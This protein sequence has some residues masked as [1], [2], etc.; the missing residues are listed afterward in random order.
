M[1]PGA[2]NASSYFSQA[3][4][5]GQ[6]ALS[7][8]GASFMSLGSHPLG[9][10]AGY[11]VAFWAL[12]AN[13]TGAG[14]RFLAFG[15]DP[16]T[17]GAV[18]LVLAPRGPATAVGSTFEAVVGGTD[19]PNQFAV[20]PNVWTHYMVSVDATNNQYTLYVNG[21]S[22]FPQMTGPIPASQP[23]VMYLGRGLVATDPYFVGSFSG[24]AIASYVLG[25]GDAQ[26]L[27][28]TA[29]CSLPPLSPPPSAPS[30]PA[31]PS[32]P[33]QFPCLKLDAF[34]TFDPGNLA[35]STLADT[36][37]TWPAA[38]FVRPT[39]N[40]SSY[41]SQGGPFGQWAL[42]LEGASFMSLG[43]HPLVT[44]YGYSV[45]FWALWAN[46]TG[47][48]ERFLA[49]GTDMST[50][51]VNLILGPRGP[52]TA[53]GSTFEAVVGGT[54][55]PNQF[56]VQPNVW[57]HYMVSVANNQYTLYV[58]G[59]SVFS[60]A[61]GTV[62]T[63]QP[64]YMYLGR[65]LVATDPYFVGSFSGLAIASFA[66]GAG[67]A[68]I[69]F[70][71]TGCRLPPPSPPS[72]PAPPPPVPFACSD[73]SAFYDF[74]P[75]SLGQGSTTLSSTP[76][77]DTRG[78]WPGTVYG[79]ATV[80]STGT[81]YGLPALQFDG[82][83]SYVDLGSRTFGQPVSVAF[84]ALWAHSVG[85]AW[86]R[87]FDFS[88][89]Y[90]PGSTPA[91][92][93]LI[94]PFGTG[95]A[96]SPQ[97]DAAIFLG[98]GGGTGNMV[99]E[100][101][102]Q[103][104]VWT[105]FVA[106]VD[107]NGLFTLYV[108]GTA[109]YSKSTAGLANTVRT[110]MYIGK[111]PYPQDPLFAGSISSF[112][113]A[114]FTLSSDDVKNLFN[115]PGCDS[116]VAGHRRRLS[117]APATTQKVARRRLTQSPASGT[118][119][120]VTLTDA[121]T[122][123]P[124]PANIS[125]GGNV[126]YSLPAGAYQLAATLRDATG[127]PV[128]VGNASNALLPFTVVAPPPP[129]PLMLPAA[130]QGAGGSV[131]VTGAFA[132]DYGWYND[133]Q[134]ATT[135]FGVGK[136][137]NASLLTGTVGVS[138]LALSLDVN[139][140][141]W[142]PTLLAGMAANLT[143]SLGG[144]ACTAV[145]VGSTPP[146]LLRVSAANL[147]DT[148]AAGVMR[149]ALQLSAALQAWL[150]A[151]GAVVALD[152]APPAL[153]AQVTASAPTNS[154]GAALGVA[155]TLLA[156]LASAS[157]APGAS[158]AG[159]T[160]L[161]L[162]AA[163]GTSTCAAS[164]DAFV[165]AISQLLV[166]SATASVAA[167]VAAGG[168]GNGTAT[169]A[170]F[171]QLSSL[172][173]GLS[174]LST[175][176]TALSAVQTSVLA[177]VNAQVLA[178]P[179]AAADNAA[180]V[181]AA[182]SALVSGPSSS[183]G[184]ISIAASAVGPTLQT[185]AT[186]AP[187]T[188]A[189]TAAV[190]A[191]LVNLTSALVSSGVALS[192]TDVTNVLT[193]LSAAS[194]VNEAPPAVANS[195]TAAVNTTLA[196]VL[197]TPIASATAG[198]LSAL[199]ASPT[200]AASSGG[201]QQLF[202]AV[203]AVITSLTGAL[204]ARVVSACDSG[205]TAAVASASINMAVSCFSG[206]Q[207]TTAALTVPGGAASV[208]AVSPALLAAIGGGSRRRTL[209][210]AGSGS[211]GASLVALSFDPHATSSAAANVSN[212]GGG[213][214][215]LQFTDT[216]TGAVLPVSG[217]AQPITMQ[218]ALSSNA[219]SSNGSMAVAA[220]YWDGQ[221]GAYSGAG[222]VAGPNPVAPNST[223]TWRTG[224]AADSTQSNLA[225]AW[226][227]AVDGCTEQFLNC[228][229]T[230]VASWAVSL[231]PDAEVGGAI[232][233]CGP[234]DTGLLRL[235]TGH[236]CPLW[237]RGGNGSSSS[238]GGCLWNVSTQRFAGPGCMALPSVRMATTHTTDFALVSM[239]TVEVASPAQVD[240]VTPSSLAKLRLLIAT[241][242]CLFGGMH[243][244]GAVLNARDQRDVRRVTTKA[245]SPALGCTLHDG[246]LYTWSLTQAPP[247][248]EVLDTVRGPAVQ[249]AG[250]LGVPYGR[251][252]LAI[253]EHLFGGQPPKRSLGR[254]HGLSAAGMRAH[255]AVLLSALSR[256]FKPDA[257]S[258]AGL[259]RAERLVA[260]AVHAAPDDEELGKDSEAWVT[261]SVTLGDDSCSPPQPA[262]APT[263]LQLSSTAL[264]QAFLVSWCLRG[265]EWTVG[266]QRLYI[267][268]LHASGVD[269]HGTRYLRLYHC[270]K[271][272]LMGHLY[273]SHG[274]LTRAR[275]L[276][277][278]ILFDDACGWEPSDA[279]AAVLQA[280]AS[281]LPMED[282]P[283]PRWRLL[284]VVRDAVQNL[285]TS[286]GMAIAGGDGE[287][288]GSADAIQDVYDNRRRD[289]HRKLSANLPQTRASGG[290][291]Q[292]SQKAHK[293]AGNS[294]SFE[295]DDPV[296]YSQ[297]AILVSIPP[298][299]REWCTAPGSAERAWTCAC[300]AAFCEAQREGWLTTPL[301]G[302]ANF[303]TLTDEAHSH[304][305]RCLEE[306][307]CGGTDPSPSSKPGDTPAERVC[308][309]ARTQ[310]AA[311]AVRA[312]RLLT[313]SRA[314]Y[315][316]SSLYVVNELQ[317]TLLALVNAAVAQ[318][319]SLALFISAYCVGS[320]RWHNG[321]LLISCLLA[322][323]LVQ[324]WLHWSRSV[325]C[326]ATARQLL[327]C[328]P[329]AA[330]PCRG[331]DGTCADLVAT[332]YP[333]TAAALRRQPLPV[334]PPA[335]TAFPNP[336]SGADTFVAGLI[337]A[338]V[339]LPFGALV[340]A[341]WSLSLAT[342]VHQIRGRTRMM[343][344][345]LL[346]RLAL[347]PFDWRFAPLSPASAHLRRR[348]GCWWATPWSINL[349]V[350]I[351]DAAP[352]ATGYVPEAAPG[353]TTTVKDLA[354]PQELHAATARAFDVF[355]TRCRYA[356]FVV[357]YLT[358]AFFSWLVITYASLV[359]DLAGSGAVSDFTGTWAA[360][361]GLSQL[362]DLRSML[363]TTLEALVLTV[364]L[365]VLWLMPN[366]RWLELQVDYMSVQAAPWGS[367]HRRLMA[368]IRHNKAVS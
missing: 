237:D 183:G 264:M 210:A 123:Q 348:L 365:D 157:I 54:D 236:D 225:M 13:A 12:W 354:L 138:S 295:G 290:L 177:S 368:F 169:A 146:V 173:S 204:V 43:S 29:G 360:S 256:S 158:W 35:G 326:C 33:P 248:S 179:Q 269:P 249:F 356:G 3:G 168:S 176:A 104:G 285:I 212:A 317:R 216:G 232:M 347:G 108:N 187:S 227:L 253:P 288:S 31:P 202:T 241:L 143:A 100:F 325:Q 189:S 101:A 220:L 185:L 126:T 6:W 14:E 193:I 242:V 21:S 284:Q 28:A 71:A 89:G 321:M 208:D 205:A 85:L 346:W 72:P 287:L 214:V 180:N 112:G 186:V 49:F 252:A 39:V 17:A 245:F 160:T 5:Y 341:L 329:D 84:W 300:V 304:L 302:N 307:G 361:V 111:S 314:T 311:W 98:A 175:N 147:S 337:G 141:S 144:V 22:V 102:S 4:P 322:M 67:D 254:R 56:A 234:G 32:P 310:V 178:S 358:W 198:V 206:G 63:S 125:A 171:A 153:S 57:N 40:A 41:F 167:A 77:A 303:R 261:A 251:L 9:T 110:R 196:G 367:L 235:F 94:A 190:A 359:V 64:A 165:T 128:G 68:Q 162:V 194:Q 230:L 70:A 195:T 339:A 30:P 224:F 274:W 228:S 338:A 50:V 281:D 38:S 250:L 363:I 255:S 293:A 74:S 145:F 188:A 362:A 86:E 103:W 87:Y 51:G 330:L 292:E 240:S 342:D 243:V 75:S 328:P 26:T 24:L 271:E 133:F 217:L 219:S 82:S 344:W 246:G 170:T 60:Q 92:E 350:A 280:S 155:T 78:N 121:V 113:V 1:A 95:T 306:A 201:Q 36:V 118:C 263:L 96:T 8:E 276:R 73:F 69:L 115:T 226:S 333:F 352:M 148:T 161:C 270:Y 172:A 343:T 117:D 191:P 62:P 199:V 114:A 19:I 163:D 229:D 152:A 291:A 105:H 331:F 366:R 80:T 320:R 313:R 312:D 231:D 364:L 48:G 142:P 76:L 318:S 283:A 159:A 273:R 324:I 106:T 81:P 299:L 10:G 135:Q 45:A 120:A 211:V 259:S 353:A 58:N 164:Q 122:L 137:M 294:I 278:A 129:S 127:T 268:R 332:H 140:G 23:T 298:Y 154:T 207:P 260:L 209:L 203:D 345:P 2:V 52:V 258:A 59:S 265:T 156:A 46:A 296:H 83:T 257:D 267:K 247:A 355:S 18:N 233:R 151:A 136:A 316:S 134:M 20:Q 93:F 323:L 301:D 221:A 37:G 44:T 213:V 66:L 47:A 91:D 42:S 215:R 61:T 357:L 27:F 327:G 286:V 53:V 335:C 119:L 334:A 349:M 79:P 315:Q 130:F 116:S 11:S 55:I 222:L 272:M 139:S 340:G 218:L 124:V 149:L 309:D 150:S 166:S 34:Y 184:N 15:P 182:L 244:L 266:Q 262:K 200:V 289:A 319:A 174:T 239:P 181:V 88:G 109:V 351:A 223:F 297:E 336:A 192:A 308:L 238:A 197:S 275:V 282:E 7:L 16:S 305:G 107:A 65:G 25:A 97:L 132:L 277:C 131:V 99:D 279:L 90:S